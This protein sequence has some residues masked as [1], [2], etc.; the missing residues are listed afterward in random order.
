MMIPVV[1]TATVFRVSQDSD[2]KRESRKIFPCQSNLFN[3]GVSL[4]F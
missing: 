4:K 2:S 1:S 3:L